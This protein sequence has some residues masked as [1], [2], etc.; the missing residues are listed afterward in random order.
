MQERIHPFIVYEDSYPLEAAADML[1]CQQ[2]KIMTEWAKG[3]INVVLDFGPEEKMDTDVWEEYDR[4][5]NRIW[6]WNIA[7]ISAP[8][9]TN[10]FPVGL[11]EKED[12][13]RK[14]CYHAYGKSGFY[15]CENHSFIEQQTAKGNE[16]GVMT[17]RHVLLF[18]HWVVPY[19]E[20]LR[21][22]VQ[23]RFALKPYPYHSSMDVVTATFTPGEG[24]RRI[25]APDKKNLRITESNIEMLRKLLAKRPV[26]PQEQEATPTETTAPQEH[27]HV[28]R[29]ALG[30]ERILAAALYVAHHYKPEIGKSFKSHA[31]C[32]EKYGYLFWK[33]E[34][35]PDHERITKVLSDATR[36]PEEWKIL[37]GNANKKK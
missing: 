29:F 36:R 23:S 8:A 4:H 9:T 14:T 31:E 18:G 20:F 1:G 11:F 7:D 30:R 34:A 12:W 28:E 32:I 24:P 13:Q 22:H 6:P 3:N 21:L 27:K 15:Y 17:V 19:S 5:Y 25:N 35:A 2:K 37:G 16:P 33:D 26:K 10:F